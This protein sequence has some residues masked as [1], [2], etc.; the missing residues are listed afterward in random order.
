MSG[1]VK[2]VSDSFV[3]VQYNQQEVVDFLPIHLMKLNS[4]SVGDIIQIKTDSVTV[5]EIAK[6]GLDKVLF[7]II[8]SLHGRNLITQF[9]LFSFWN[10]SAE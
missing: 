10:R 5:D 2:T 6:K 3:Q 9:N 1:T 4:F 8:N 7:L